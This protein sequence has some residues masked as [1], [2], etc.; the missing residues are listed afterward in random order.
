MRSD[1]TLVASS[2]RGGN[3]YTKRIGRHY[4]SGWVFWGFFEHQLLNIYQHSSGSSHL[5]APSLSGQGSKREQTGGRLL[6]PRHPRPVNSAELSPGRGPSTATALACEPADCHHCESR[7]RPVGH[8]HAADPV[9]GVSEPTSPESWE[10]V[11]KAP[12][13]Q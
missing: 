2:C 3:I 8:I 13:M 9:C 11:S 4:R 7:S 10:N 12:G 6:R 5:E 1:P